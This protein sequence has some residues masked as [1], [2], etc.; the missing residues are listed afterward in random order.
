MDMAN[1]MTPLLT[2]PVQ[3]IP[4]GS[5]WRRQEVRE[6]LNHHSLSKHGFILTA[7]PGYEYD[8]A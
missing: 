4:E 2:P 6:P 7:R 8:A 3:T 1:R 5:G